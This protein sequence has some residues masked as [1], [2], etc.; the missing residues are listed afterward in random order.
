MFDKHINLGDTFDRGDG[1][2]K[3]IQFYKS[4]FGPASVA[5]PLHYIWGNHDILWLGASVGNPICCMTAL[6]ISM[7]YNNVDLLFRYGF[8]LDKLKNFALKCYK[9]VPTG[10]YVKESNSD[11]WPLEV[12]I[13]MTKVLLILESKLTVSCLKEALAI[14]GDI[15]YEKYYQRYV[16]LLALLPVGIREDKNEWTEYI[17]EN[18]LFTDVYFPSIDPAAPEKL[19]EEEKEVVDDLVE[20]FCRLPRLQDDIKWMF[21]K[22]E[23]YRVMDNTIYYHAALPATEDMELDEIK[24]MKGKKL[25]DFIQRDL[26]RISIKHANNEVVT[27]REKML[28]W[29]LW[30][31]ENSP[32]FCKSKMA[33]LERAV[34]NKEVAS[35]DFLTTWKEVANPYYKNIRNDDFLNKILLDFHAERICMGH[36]PVKNVEQGIL[37]DNLR[38]FIVDGGASSAYGDRGAVLISSPDYTYLTFHP[39]LKDLLEAEKKNQLPDLNIIHL[40]EKKKLKL[41]QM[42]KGYFLR[43][44]LEA[45]NE[46]LGDKIGPYYESY[47]C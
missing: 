22:G 9:E 45:I 40:E 14:P 3:L 43:R 17:K 36:T 39:N 33:T 42:D 6:R 26:K 25:L 37:S 2:D 27:H 32:F 41:A 16:D 21:E 1:A 44:E 13:K 11:L 29:F 24:G 23:T 38:A 20:Q 10:Q 18:R 35:K 8:N 5:S 30:C 12:A 47:F 7:R 46:L 19:T 15:D 34:F 28:F 31:G 4:Y